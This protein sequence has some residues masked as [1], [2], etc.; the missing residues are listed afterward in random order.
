M[1]RGIPQFL[2]INYIRRTR[3]ALYRKDF[4]VSIEQK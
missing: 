4:R 1:F 2:A 3:A